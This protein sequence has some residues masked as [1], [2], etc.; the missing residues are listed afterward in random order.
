MSRTGPFSR[1]LLATVAG[2]AA[3]L[4]PAQEPAHPAFARI[5]WTP[6][7]RLQDGG[8]LQ[9]VARA[10]FTAVQLPVG[11]DPDAAVAA[12]LAFYVDQP[13]GKG[14]LELRDPE[15]NAVRDAYE[16]AR[17]PTVLLRPGCLSDP[18]TLTAA[19]AATRAR[20]AETLDHRPLFVALGDEISVTRRGNPLDLCWSAACLA[21]FR[22]HL[23]GRHGDLGALNR[24]WGTSYRTWEAVLPLSTD[25]IRRRELVGESLPRNLRPWAEHREFMDGR[26]AAAVATMA[27]A[28]R[29]LEPNLPVGLTGMQPPGAFGGHDYARLLPGLSLVEAYDLGGAPA[30]ARSLVPTA[31]R[32]ATLQAPPADAPTRL[33]AARLAD[34]IARG[35]NAVVVWNA[36][37]VFAADGAP[38]S[39]GRQV[40]DALGELAGVAEVCAGSRVE[41]DPIWIVESQASVRAWW[42]LDSA[43]DGAT[44][45]RRLSSYES[46]HSTS[47]AARA[48]WVALLRDLGL[49]PR[50]VADDILPQRLLRENPRCLVLGAAIAL[51]D[52]SV[53]AIGA[54]VRAGGTLLMDHTPALYD[55]HL[56]LRSAGALDEL[57][58]VQRRGLAW[59][60]LLVRQG[61]PAA[62]GRLRSGAFAAEAGLRAD[63]AEPQGD[64]R[65]F[66]E[67]NV[68]RGRAVYLNLAVCDYPRI[69]LQVDA[70]QAALDLRARVRNVTQLARLLPPFEVRGEGLPTC[71]ERVV[72]RTADGRRVLVVRVDALDQ[73]AVLQ[74]LAQRGP[75]PVVLHTPRPVR[76]RALGSD[77]V[78]GPA[79]RF[80]FRLD[81]WTGL[82]LEQVGG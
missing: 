82:F 4:L 78:L 74:T 44:W 11:A 80:E 64:H 56:T 33:V 31:Y 46:A 21:A 60:H 20:V 61:A 49:Q 66:L 58:G 5:L 53:Q 50:F 71:I 34:W 45:I 62:A 23:Q 77:V 32:L 3:A 36:D 6:A 40:L 69:R 38:T 57:C 59:Q 54:W 75:I 9:R 22:E 55:E 42:M 63:L 8:F 7:A 28:V 25:Q 37:A 51:S 1:G 41:E 15:W 17:D 10:G 52:R 24:A 29:S 19:A 48:G 30:L 12:G 27:S 79:D 73:P 18:A 14:L 39:F 81:V 68:G 43:Q 65:V 13:A 35:T 16:R 67:K 47:Q 76:L 72:L 26:L 2:A 70:I